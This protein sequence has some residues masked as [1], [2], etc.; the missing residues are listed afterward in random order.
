MIITEETDEQGNVYTGYG[1]QALNGSSN[2]RK[3]LHRVPDLFVSK[4]RCLTFVKMCNEE[5]VA[6]FHLLEVI[7]N[8][9]ADE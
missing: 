7:D 4:E 5:E 2:E 3:C 9:L 8:V 6:I 1:I